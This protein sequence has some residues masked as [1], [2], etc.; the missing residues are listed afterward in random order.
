MSKNK[1]KITIKAKRLSR[2]RL[3]LSIYKSNVNFVVQIIDDSKNHTVVSENSILMKKSSLKDKALV[4][5]KKLVEKAKSLNINEVYY[6][7]SRRYTGT[8]KL[9]IEELRANDLKV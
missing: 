1:A 4:V 3:R 9:L 8:V 7:N 2:S 5:A 6:D